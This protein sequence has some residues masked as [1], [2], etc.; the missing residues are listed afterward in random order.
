[1]PAAAMPRSTASETAQ[2]AKVKKSKLATIVSGAASGMMVSACVQPLDVLRTRMQADAAKG[3]FLNTVQALQ[4]VVKEVRRPGRPG[5]Q[6]KGFSCA[7]L[8]RRR[9]TS[10]PLARLSVVSVGRAHLRSFPALTVFF[11][12]WSLPVHALSSPSS[13]SSPDVH[14]PTPVP[15]QRDTPAHCLIHP[16]WVPLPAGCRAG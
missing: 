10:P 1:M 16:A 12:P 11:C 15:I 4:T 5:G 9:C 3:V 7:P 8:G 2:V 14:T 6:R 13:T